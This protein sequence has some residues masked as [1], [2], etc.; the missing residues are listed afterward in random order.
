MRMHKGVTLFECLIYLALFSCIATAS[1]AIIAR[2]WQSRMRAAAIEQSHLTL[3][4]A[5]DALAREMQ[6]APSLRTQ[7]KCIM[8]TTLIW[9]IKD[10][11]RNDRCWTMHNKALFR[12]EG[13]YATASGQ[14]KKKHGS[15][16]APITELHFDCAGAER[17]THV[18][19]LLSD[20]ITTLQETIALHN[21][22]IHAQ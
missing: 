16:I 12:I 13:S 11:K 3:Y 17:I 7:W 1:V 6:S 20:G 21:R 18:T 2:L 8:P 14:W 10:S 15:T 5:F 4:S 19:V 9:P 22:I